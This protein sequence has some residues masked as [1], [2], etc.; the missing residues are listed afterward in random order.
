MPTSAFFRSFVCAAIP[1][2]ICC[3]ILLCLTDAGRRLKCFLPRLCIRR[4]SSGFRLKSADGCITVPLPSAAGAFS[5]S[6]RRSICPTAANS[7]NAA[8]LSRAI[9]RP[10]R[11]SSADR[12]SPSGRISCLTAAA[13]RSAWKS[14]RICGCPRRRPR[15]SAWAAHCSSPTLPHPTS[16]SPSTATAVS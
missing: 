16:W 2:A 5:A 12:V 13:S 1:A 9:P 6:F 8:G 10:I 14:A 7:T 4:S 3:S 11:S 15:P